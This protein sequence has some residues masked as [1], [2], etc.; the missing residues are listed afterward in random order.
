[1]SDYEQLSAHMRRQARRM[2]R[3]NQ[4]H[5]REEEKRRNQ[6]EAQ[7]ERD[8]RDASVYYD[9]DEIDEQNVASLRDSLGDLSEHRIRD[10]RDLRSFWYRQYHEAQRD[11]NSR[12]I[13][14]A[15]IAVNLVDDELDRRER[16]LPPR[17]GLNPLFKE[18]E[19]A[20]R[21]K[22]ARTASA[23]SNQNPSQS[24]RPIDAPLPTY[25][26]WG[27]ATTPADRRAE[28]KAAELIE[29]IRAWLTQHGWPL[30]ADITVERR[31]DRIV[32]SWHHA[33]VPFYGRWIARN[34]RFGI[35][36]AVPPAQQNLVGVRYADIAQQAC[37]D[38]TA[39]EP[40]TRLWDYVHGVLSPGA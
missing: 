40:S 35:F 38:I 30:P 11:H 19:Q 9:L 39:I 14:E 10:L 21:R 18:L 22:A 12:E 6:E 25:A 28:A 2:D 15:G 27:P 34:D 33:G 20:V 8:S 36:V 16:H 24:P 26:V 37:A 17:Q 5:Q 7:I 4:D 1:M 31:P 13:A 32:I 23:P 29:Q 3:E